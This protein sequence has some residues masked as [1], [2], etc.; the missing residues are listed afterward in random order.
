M[1]TR[2]D[3]RVLVISIFDRGL[4]RVE[5]AVERLDLSNPEL[6]G[7]RVSVFFTAESDL[8]RSTGKHIEDLA[9]WWGMALSDR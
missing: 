4:A 1:V 6:E 8:W 9:I 3:C 5:S 2:I 7:A